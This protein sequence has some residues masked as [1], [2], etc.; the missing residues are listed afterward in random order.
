MTSIRILIGGR[1]A[2]KKIEEIKII[3]KLINL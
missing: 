1:K 2:N 3:E